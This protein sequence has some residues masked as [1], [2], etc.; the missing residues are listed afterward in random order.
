[1][2]DVLDDA[3]AQERVMSDVSM[4]LGVLV[5]TVAWFGLYSV[6]AY[7]VSQRR[8][9]LGVRLALGATA[10]SL[11]GIVLRD[12]LFMVVP[13]LA[14]GIPLGVSAGRLLSTQLY[15]VR[16]DDVPTLAAVACLVTAVGCCRRR[17]P[18]GPTK[19]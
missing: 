5:V 16:A 11:A 12:S 10:R 7:E 14:V 4:L 2:A 6:M 19:Y 17:V 13:A 9:E 3:I 8:R 15:D 1:M 18:R